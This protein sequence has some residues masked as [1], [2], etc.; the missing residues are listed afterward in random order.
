MYVAQL[1]P[2][3]EQARILRR[4][5]ID[6]ANRSDVT[7]EEKDAAWQMLADLTTQMRRRNIQISTNLVWSP[8]PTEPAIEGASE[9]MEAIYK[10][11][12]IDLWMVK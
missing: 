3:L 8:T 1:L 4:S 12:S 6:Y 10:H 5:L 11:E 7:E 9:I 2:D